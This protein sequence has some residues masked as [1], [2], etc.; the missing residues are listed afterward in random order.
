MKICKNPKCSKEF[1]PVRR[2]VFC[3]AECRTNYWTPLV[4]ERAKQK[5]ANRKKALVKA[6]MA[7]LNTSRQRCVYYK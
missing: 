1:K 3:C 6:K 5:T 4:L 7:N 2:Q